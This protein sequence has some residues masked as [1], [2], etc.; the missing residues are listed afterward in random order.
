VTGRIKRRIL[1]LGVGWREE[2]LLQ[3]QDG[4]MELCSRIRSEK[5]NLVPE[6][7]G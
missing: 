5:T 6:E 2:I 7:Y 1:L 4:E 3:E